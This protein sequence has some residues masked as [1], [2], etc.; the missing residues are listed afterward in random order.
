M[1]TITKRG[2]TYL[3][4]WYRIDG[5]RDS[6]TCPTKQAALDLRR[7]VDHER[8]LGRD[9][10]PRVPRE[11][12]RLEDAADAYLK[13]RA[14]TR[15]PATLVAL[16]YLL[17]YATRFVA[18]RTKTA[19]PLVSALSRG[20]VVDYYASMPQ[21]SEGQG[22]IK[23]CH[24]GSEAIVRAAPEL[25]ARKRMKTLACAHPVCQERVRYWLVDATSGRHIVGRSLEELEQPARD[26]IRSV[27]D[28]AAA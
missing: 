14:T 9:W 27:S 7:E 18:E 26:F 3:V 28:R 20:L 6:R 17:D 10:S 4:R 13:D 5:S 12:P 15:R 8:A 11:V 19:E 24:L 22:R 16:G 25:F 23:T 21:L 2:S 1:A